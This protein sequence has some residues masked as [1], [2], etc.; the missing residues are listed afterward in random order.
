M[1][2]LV[3]GGLLV[4]GRLRA[5]LLALPIAFVALLALTF[6][7]GRPAEVEILPLIQEYLPMFMF[8][9]L[10]VLLFSGYPVAFV[11]GGVAIVFGLLGYMIGTFRLV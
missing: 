9:A 1:A 8:V 2:K 5:L 3:P 6:W 7:L 10:G 4:N 11:L